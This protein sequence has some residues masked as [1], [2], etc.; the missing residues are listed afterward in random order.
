[1]VVLLWNLCMIFYAYV[2][3][4]YY[5]VVF[6]WKGVLGLKGAKVLDFNKMGCES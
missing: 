2:R 6:L 5:I 4:L 1:M 3:Q